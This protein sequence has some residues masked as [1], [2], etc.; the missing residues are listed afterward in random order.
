MFLGFVDKKKYRVELNIGIGRLIRM[1]SYDI[2][3]YSSS[4][5]T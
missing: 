5:Y 3:L 4:L 2:S 1:S